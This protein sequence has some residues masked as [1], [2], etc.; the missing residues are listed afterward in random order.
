MPGLLVGGAAPA[1][2]EAGADVLASARSIASQSLAV[3]HQ[4]RPMHR[5]GCIRDLIW[6]EVRERLLAQARERRPVW[7][8]GHSLGAAL[9]TLAA[10]RLGGVRGLYTFGSPAVGDQAFAED[11]RVNAYRYVHHRDIV[12]RVPPFGWYEGEEKRR[13][14]YVHVGALKYID[15]DGRLR[16]HTHG[17]LSP[18]GFAQDVAAFVV[19]R[20]ARVRLGHLLDVA[21]EPFDDHAPLFYALQAWNVYADSRPDAGVAS[22]GVAGAPGPGETPVP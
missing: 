14:D 1:S 20:G 4:R 21:R 11:F 3:L 12:T 19:N 22:L 16:D 8:A 17:L 6:I 10:D 15:G 9:A 7:M 2:S 13:G 18:A 5:S